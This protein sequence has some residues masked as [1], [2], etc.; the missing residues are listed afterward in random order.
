MTISLL[1]GSNLF[2]LRRFCVGAALGLSLLA[3][4]PAHAQTNL[5][6]NG[7]FEASSPS[8]GHPTVWHVYNSA[9]VGISATLGSPYSGSGLAAF[10]HAVGRIVPSGVITQSV[11]VTRT[12][13]PY[14]L[15]AFLDPVTGAYFS[16]RLGSQI[17]FEGTVSTG[18][19]SYG[20]KVTP[21]ATDETVRF[22]AF[23]ERG[24]LR[25]DHVSLT[26]LGAPSAP[27]IDPRAG[28]PALALALGGLALMS[29]RRRKRATAADKPREQ[30][31]S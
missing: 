15:A 17:A 5:L 2:S 8:G 19:A 14:H 7:G 30:G 16:E 27:E 22:F 31:L 9:K 25:M 21:T 28:A 23:G 13:L 26:R 12:G 1:G 20:G 4:G 24:S 18:Y 6:K 11:H 3:C 10:T 29:E